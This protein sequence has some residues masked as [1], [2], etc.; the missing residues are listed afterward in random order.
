MMRIDI[1][2]FVSR[3][4]PA[5]APVVEIAMYDG[6]WFLRS[7]AGAAYRVCG[8]DLVF[9]DKPFAAIPFNESDAEKVRLLERVTRDW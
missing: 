3:A 9:I 6:E 5:D 1:A 8:N 4:V 7:G 2:P